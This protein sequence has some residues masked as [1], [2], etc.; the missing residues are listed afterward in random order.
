M[1]ARTGLTSLKSWEVIA[2][3]VLSACII[4][5]RVFEAWAA[6]ANHAHMYSARVTYLEPAEQAV[7]I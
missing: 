5:S 6:P 1:A 2:D 7:C 3:V 4:H